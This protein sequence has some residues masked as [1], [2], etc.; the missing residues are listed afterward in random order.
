MVWAFGPDGREF[1]TPGSESAS[2]MQVTSNHAL[3]Q[4]G[5]RSWR[6]AKEVVAQF[7]PFLNPD[8]EYSP[9]DPYFLSWFRGCLQ[10]V[11]FYGRSPFAFEG[12]EIAAWALSLNTVL[13]RGTDAMAFVA[14][15][16]AT[17]ELHCVIEG[18]DRAWAAEMVNQAV[19]EGI[20]RNMQPGTTIPLTC[21]AELRK[22]LLED[23][24]QPVVLSSSMGDD[25]PQLPDSWEPDRSEEKREESWG[26]LLVEEQF[27]LGLA[28]LLT[29]PPTGD[30]NPPL[31]PESLRGTRFRHELD[32]FDLIDNDTEKVRAALAVRPVKEDS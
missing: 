13:S 7:G 9:L 8:S 1:Y 29:E 21:W 6:S 20:L 18:T 24:S 19:A 2:M 28:E 26:D 30:W 16:A 27:A 15:V 10:R 3:G 32:Y 14:K 11:M 25:F 4:I 5:M 17:H 31:G 22:L 23:D 12:R